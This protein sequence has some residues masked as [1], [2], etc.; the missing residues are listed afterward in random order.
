M[1]LLSRGLRIGEALALPRRHI[2]VL[3][4]KLIVA[5]SLTEV[6]GKFTFGP[7]KNHQVREVP[8]PRGL[9][10]EI[11]RHLDEGVAATTDALVFTGRTAEPVHYTSVRR[12]FDAA[13][14]RL[15]LL[16]VTP[17]SLRASCASWVAES[18]GVLEAA[19]RLGHG[20]SSVTRRHYARPMT[21]GD[22]VV[23]ERLDAARAGARETVIDPAGPSEWARSG[24]DGRITPVEEV[25]GGQAHPL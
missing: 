9:L 8:L 17:H 18:D 15:G 6:D 14:R 16:R 3:G 13:C 19:R 12:S 2:D 4:C 20:R 22:A 11:T 1:G 24:H 25:G 10:P 5:E 23:A 21:G 7:T